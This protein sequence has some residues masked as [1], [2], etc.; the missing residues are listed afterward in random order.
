[1]NSVEA[2][3][4]DIVLKVRIAS[5]YEL[6]P[7]ARGEIVEKVSELMADLG[8]KHNFLVWRTKMDW[9]ERNT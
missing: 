2:V 4:E 3:T 7:D 6:H 5:F 8:K 9:I 1:M